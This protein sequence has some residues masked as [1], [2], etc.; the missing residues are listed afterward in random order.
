MSESEWVHII[1]D[2]DDMQD[3]ARTLL[4]AARAAGHDPAVVR[5]ADGGFSV[6]AVV[7]AAAF[8]PEPPPPT[9]PRRTDAAED[10]GP[11][12]DQ[13]SRRRRGGRS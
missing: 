6:P 4:D 2:S 8:P 1:V 13:P 3:V 5:T 12:G 9:N 10:K 11:V 7:A